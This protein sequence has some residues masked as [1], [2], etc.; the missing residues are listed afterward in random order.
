[1]AD[2]RLR[3]HR[4]RSGSVRGIEELLDTDLAGVVSRAR[5]LQEQLAGHDAG[6]GPLADPAV[7]SAWADAVAPTGTAW[8]EKRLEWQRELDPTE[9]VAGVDREWPA[10]LA[11]ICDAVRSGTTPSPSPLRPAQPVAFEELLLPALVVARRRLLARLGQPVADLPVIPK[12]DAGAYLDLERS[13]LRQLVAIAGRVLDHVFARSRPPG[14]ALLLGLG[15]PARSAAGRE[16]YDDFVRRHLEDGW[17]GLLEEFPVMGRLVATLVAQWVDATSE[18]LQRI[19]DDWDSLVAVIGVETGST[20]VT[21]IETGL[22]DRHRGGRTVSRLLLSDGSQLVYK[23]RSLAMEAR[24]NELIAWTNQKDALSPDLRAVAVLDRG[25]HGWCEYVAPDACA[26]AAEVET[27]FERAGRLL[28]L[29]HVLR[30]TDCHYENVVA[31]AD[32][33]V[34]VDAETLLYPDPLPLFGDTSGGGDSPLADPLVAGSVLR[35]GLLPQWQVGSS[36]AFDN[37]GLAGPSR[38]G[39]APAALDWLDVNTDDM[40]LRPT[41]ARQTTSSNLARVGDVVMSVLDHEEALVRGFSSMHRLLQDNRREL[42]RTGGALDLMRTTPARF[43][44]RSTRVYGQMLESLTEPESLA[45]GLQAGLRL[46]QLARAYLPAPQT[47]RAWPAFAA[48]VRALIRQDVPLFETTPDS[49]D[50]RSSDAST[51]TSA[52]QRPGHEAVVARIESLDEQDL[53][54]QVDVLRMALAARREVQAPRP[55]PRSPGKVL[56]VDDDA[57]VAGAVSIAEQLERDAL[58]DGRGSVTWIG[59]QDGAVAD[60]QE[61]GVID[62]FLYDGRAGIGLFA[63]ALFARTGDDRWRRLALASLAGPRERLRQVGAD[64]RLLASRLH[65]IGGASGLGSLVYALTSAGALLDP[66]DRVRAARGR[67][68]TR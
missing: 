24:F 66:A 47:P 28:C 3:H 31:S 50:L 46:E 22:G 17:S 43:I 4:H 5:L 65:G 26:G 34:L 19:E 60:C 15:V 59:V 16:R 11:E 62:D 6:E 68:R 8:F 38:R 64:G 54:R 18:Q 41:P 10:W 48:E 29:L 42:L 25:A 57:L 13:L 61:V 27:F 7:R 36:G 9:G 49:L 1:M 51:I 45:D 67:A 37:S 55:R 39:A 30:A 58:P 21:A 53:V 35:V 52:F 12:V 56:A 40:R 14:R 33:P 20:V 32:H 63:A 2:V 23:P 44:Q